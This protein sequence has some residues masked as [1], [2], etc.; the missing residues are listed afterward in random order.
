MKLR[1]IYN[2]D[3]YIEVD[4]QIVRWRKKRKLST[5]MPHVKKMKEARRKKAEEE[6]NKPKIVNIFKFEK[7]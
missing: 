4:D 1:K 6:R 5:M 2:Q 7:Y 3:K